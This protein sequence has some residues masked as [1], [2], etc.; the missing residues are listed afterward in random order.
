L[1]VCRLSAIKFLK[2]AFLIVFFTIALSLC[3]VGLV[4]I[5]LWWSLLFLVAIF[6]SVR[7]DWKSKKPQRE[8]PNQLRSP[9]T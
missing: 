2:M 3:V 9:T 6:E 1:L 8:P 7:G 4:V 5:S